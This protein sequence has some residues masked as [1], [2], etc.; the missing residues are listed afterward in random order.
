VETLA[1]RGYRFIAPVEW[2]TPGSELAGQRAGAAG[3]PVAVKPLPTVP[4]PPPPPSAA[5]DTGLPRPHRGLTRL[6]FV[7]A[8]LMYLIF[9]AVALWR[10]D[11]IRAVSGLWLTNRGWIVAA[12]VLISGCVGIAVRLYLTTAVLFDY[13]GLGRS[14]RRIFPLV[15]PLDQLWALAP[16]LLL[17]QIGVGAAFAACAA[18]LYLP[19]SERTLIRMAY[20]YR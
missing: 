19:F 9:Y 4:A 15:L 16:F 6:L 3:E 18:L 17:G 13:P 20:D 12:I 1:R 2:I 14:F 8:Q 10:L 5:S 7:L 11:H